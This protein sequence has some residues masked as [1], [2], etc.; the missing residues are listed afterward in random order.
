M[1]DVGSLL[2]NE[3]RL[4]SVSWSG[5]RRAKTDQC[6]MDGNTAELL[7]STKRSSTVVNADVR[8]C[9]YV[10]FKQASLSS[11][12]EYSK[13]LIRLKQAPLQACS[14]VFLFCFVL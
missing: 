9:V 1:E 5:K 12:N 3:I 14:M 2:G 8:L 4:F 11:L 6:G 10:C 13:D 7:D